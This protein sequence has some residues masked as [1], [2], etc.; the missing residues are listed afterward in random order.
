MLSIVWR[1][2][3]M[4]CLAPFFL[5]PVLGL[6]LVPVQLYLFI[7]MAAHIWRRV[8]RPPSPPAATTSTPSDDLGLKL[9]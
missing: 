7:S 3:L 6:L 9:H 4:V 8:N 2:V 1:L 5:V